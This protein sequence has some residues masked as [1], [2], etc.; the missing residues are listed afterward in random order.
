VAAARHGK[1]LGRGHDLLAFTPSSTLGLPQFVSAADG[2]PPYLDITYPVRAASVDTSGPE[3]LTPLIGYVRLGLSLEQTFADA[4]STVELLTGLAVLVLACTCLTGF[5]LVRWFIAP[6]QSLKQTMV[7]LADGDLH[8]R[9]KVQ[10]RDEIG[11]LAAAYNGMADK[12]VQKHEEISLLNAELEER[13][14]QRTRQLRDLA[15][16]DPLTGLYNRRHFAEVVQNQTAGAQR[17]GQ[18]LSCMMLDLDDFKGVNDRLGHQR[19][20]ELLILVAVTITTELRRSDLAARYGGDEFIILLPA[21]GPA[22]AHVLA[23]RMMVKLRQA[24]ALQ[25]PESGVGMSIGIASLSELESDQADD[26]IRAA[27]AALY[28]A[29]TAGKNRIATATSRGRNAPLP[30]STPAS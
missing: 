16:R 29:K 15:A 22:E 7:N 18:D 17:Y 11:E 28:D 19:G 6:L 13:V 9:C 3:P 10:R 5:M 2:R 27:D 30:S 21:T 26:L 20:D 1:T 23:E 12:L 4:S 24:V 25:M 8:A 14:Q